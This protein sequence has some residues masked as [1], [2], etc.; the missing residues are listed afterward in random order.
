M[1]MS[2]SWTQRD[3]KTWAKIDSLNFSDMKA[4]LLGDIRTNTVLKKQAGAA[5]KKWVATAEIAYKR[6][7]FVCYKYPE[8]TIIPSFH[9]DAFWHKHILYTDNYIKVCDQLFGRYLHHAPDKRAAKSNKRPI[10]NSAAFRKSSALF[11]AEFGDP[12]HGKEAPC[13]TGGGGGGSPCEV[14]DPDRH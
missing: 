7:L 3:K 5:P 10:G 2:S 6:F 4:S 8:T 1:T 14:R 9:V 12:G 11:L 13:S